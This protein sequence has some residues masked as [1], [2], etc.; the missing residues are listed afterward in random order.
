MTLYGVAFNY[1]MISQDHNFFTI[2]ESNQKISEMIFKTVPTYVKCK[3]VCISDRNSR[4]NNLLTS[5]K[6][7]LVEISKCNFRKGL[8]PW[9]KMAKQRE[10]FYCKQ[11]TFMK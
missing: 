3:A 10:T 2:L 8:R 9:C 4:E 5:I 1:W 11:G 7:S 6:F